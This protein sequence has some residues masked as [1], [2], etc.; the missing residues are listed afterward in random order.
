MLFN[1]QKLCEL[2]DNSI[3]M[4]NAVCIYFLNFLL[5][6]INYFF[7]IFIHILNYV[8]IRFQKN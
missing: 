3:K 5:I 2:V 6:F 1:I 7:L 4:I 8:K